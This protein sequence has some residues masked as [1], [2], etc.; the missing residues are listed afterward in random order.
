[1]QGGLP[2][3]V[4]ALI[5]PSDTGRTPRLNLSQCWDWPLLPL[6]VAHVCTS[7][8]PI[9]CFIVVVGVE[10]IVVIYQKITVQILNINQSICATANQQITIFL[11]AEKQLSLN[12]FSEFT[13][14]VQ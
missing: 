4:H 10:E 11:V 6:F 9:Y 8:Y 5:D 3:R 12:T 13:K 2:C 7:V 1:M 14:M